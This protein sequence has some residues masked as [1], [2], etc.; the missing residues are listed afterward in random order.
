M[1]TDGDVVAAT[2]ISTDHGGRPMYRLRSE[3]SDDS[4]EVWDLRWEA[5]P[6]SEGPAIVRRTSR[7]LFQR[8]DATGLLDSDVRISP[9][10]IAALLGE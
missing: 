4:G 3:S 2:A 6:P 7:E 8:M 9:G 10:A 5:M 1:R